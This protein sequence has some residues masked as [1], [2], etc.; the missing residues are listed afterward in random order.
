MRES[1]DPL[2]GCVFNIQRFSVHDGPGIRTTIFLKGC[3]L[4]CRWCSNPESQLREPQLVFWDAQ[5]IHCNTCLTVCER[6]AIVIDG[7]E[8]KR[9]LAQR[10]DRC[11]R[12]LDECYA[13]ALEQI[14]RTMTVDQVISLVEED[15]PF[16]EQSAGGITLSG[17][18][19]T[20]QPEFSRQ[21]LHSCKERGIHTAIET[22][23]HAPWQAWQPL[24]PYLD[25][26]LYDV[27][28]V[29]PAQH[30]VGTGVSNEL[31]LSNLERLV[32][33]GKD[34]IVRRPVIPG[35]NDTPASTHALAQY[36]RRLGGIQEIDLLPY[37]R[38]GQG[39]YARLERDYPMG[40]TPALEEEHVAGLQE[41][42]S[43]YGLRV[44]TGG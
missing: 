6:G 32:E 26:I 27:K 44:K 8:R 42:L 40:A 17:G 35:W 36:V 11:G 22:C 7:A 37:H 13:G 19:P 24:L 9:V 31:I 21:V 5:C 3:P 14:G 30:Q 34:I 4:R 1:L 43:S 39:K 29:D 38:F 15:R 12:C 28:E 2:T 16:Y 33:A 25:F 41:I 20:L 18:E 23:G 10:C